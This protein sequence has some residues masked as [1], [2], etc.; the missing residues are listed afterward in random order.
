MVLLK[1]VFM[2]LHGLIH[3][4]LCCLARAGLQPL[5]ANQGRHNRGIGRTLSLPFLQ[6]R[7]GPG[8]ARCL[9]AAEEPA[10]GEHHRYLQAGVHEVTSE[11]MS[12]RGDLP[13]KQTWPRRLVAFVLLFG[14]HEV[15]RDV[16]SL[17]NAERGRAVVHACLFAVQ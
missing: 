6:T 11:C 17:G 8:P 5:P 15:D 2:V 12:F 13:Q 7:S 9:R 14:A 16:F 3:L 4:S 10:G 1:E